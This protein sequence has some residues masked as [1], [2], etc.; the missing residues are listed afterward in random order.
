M[1]DLSRANSRDGDYYRVIGSLEATM[2]AH[3]KRL[4]SIDEKLDRLL[5]MSSRVKG[6]WMTLSA[7]MSVAAVVGAFSSRIF[8]VLRRVLLG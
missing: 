3:E 8:E 7:L 2:V 6:G 5:D 4:D 1:T